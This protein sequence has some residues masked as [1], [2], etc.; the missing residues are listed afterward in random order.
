MA[1][2]AEGAEVEAGWPLDPVA[3]VVQEV[4][5]AIPAGCTWLLPVR[6]ADAS[7]VDFRIGAVGAQGQDL[8]GRGA[9]RVGA[10]LSE[11]YPSMVDG[12]LWRAYRDAMAT[13]TSSRVPDFRYEEKR[14]G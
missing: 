1:A 7:V 14:P 12:P 8:H 6:D 13:G 4:L 10:L 9:S 2:E 5:S 3:A 11:L